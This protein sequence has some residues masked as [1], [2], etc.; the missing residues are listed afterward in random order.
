MKGSA[1]PDQPL[2]SRPKRLVAPA[3]AMVPLKERRLSF[4]SKWDY[5]P[6][7]EDHQSYV[8]APR[9]ELFIGGRFVTPHSGKYFPSIN[10]ATEEKLTEIATADAVDVDSAVKSA[11][12]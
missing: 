2:R 4:G 3:R 5:A 11:R 9:H 8:I 12:R 1:K 10:P 6:A 7:L